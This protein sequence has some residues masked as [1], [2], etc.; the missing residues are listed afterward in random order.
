[1]VTDGP[2]NHSIEACSPI[3]AAIWRQGSWHE[4]HTGQPDRMNKNIESFK[5]LIYHDVLQLPPLSFRLGREGSKHY[6]DQVNS[7]KLI[8]VPRRTGLVPTPCWRLFVPRLLIHY[9][10]MC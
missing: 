9:L 1:M 2:W 6:Q 4:L 10:L 7:V 3:H 8:G 5:F